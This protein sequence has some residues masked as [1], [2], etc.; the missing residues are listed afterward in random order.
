MECLQNPSCVIIS[1]NV[2]EMEKKEGSEE[3]GR[4]ERCN[5]FPKMAEIV[6]SII[7]VL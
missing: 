6:F 1:G 3:E 7:Y 2:M 5:F 4:Q